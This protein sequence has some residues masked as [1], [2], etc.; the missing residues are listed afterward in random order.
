MKM[1]E[2]YLVIALTII[3]VGCTNKTINSPAQS[4]S[5]NI[6]E[7]ENNEK[8]FKTNISNL[9][10]TEMSCNYF[11]EIELDFV[12]NLDKEHRKYDMVSGLALNDINNDGLIDI[13]LVNFI[14][15]S[16]IFW[17]KGDL[18]FEKED[19]PISKGRSV[20]LID[21]NGDAQI[22]I[23][24]T[25]FN[26]TP[27]LFENK[28]ADKKTV[29]SKTKMDF[30]NYSF[31][32]DFGDIDLDGDLDLVLSSYDVELG[33]VINDYKKGSNIYGV[34]WYINENDS[35]R[36]KL[37]LAHRSNALVTT[38]F[39]IDNNSYPDIFVGNDMEINDYAFLCY[40]VGCTLKKIFNK[41]S[42]FTMSYYFGDIEND[43][44][45]D[46]FSS[47][48]L[49]YEPEL[50]KKMLEDQAHEPEYPS[51]VKRNTLQ[52]NRNG[53]FLEDAEAR[54]IDA[55]G[56]SWSSKFADINNDG[57]LDLYIV[58][59]M[60]KNYMAS[61]LEEKNKG[62]IEENFMLINNGSG[63]F[64]NDK[65][66]GL[67]STKGG[68]GMSFADLDN[69]GYLD[70]VVN[71]LLDNASIFVNNLCNENEF[72]EFELR[73]PNSKNVYSIGAKV[74]LNTSLG[75]LTRTIRSSSGYLSGDPYRLHFGLGKNTTIYKTKV[76]W[77]DGKVSSFSDIKKNKVNKIKR[78]R[79]N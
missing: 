53:L 3:I 9:E 31:S 22:D 42:F 55:T 30:M 64:Y 74:I 77:P 11:E 35:F 71:N 17:N 27:K 32:S 45:Y 26:S 8:N 34:S 59:G 78:E 16:S 2:L 54:G 28:L 13:F 75:T 12:L 61:N 66:L 46:V 68:R 41:T 73:Q 14:G 44:D 57:F 65:S 23:F 63:Y 25:I 49:L 51:Q 15:N 5:N 4:I 43:G 58:N 10:T 21:Y 70:I 48:M 47:D 56:W 72:V 37:F 18:K 19:F 50:K 39:D 62:L 38:L 24:I 1:K 7:L 6:Y 79:E 76:I 67:N 69:D 33:D 29:F 40:E 36:Q 52:V 20:N 60:L